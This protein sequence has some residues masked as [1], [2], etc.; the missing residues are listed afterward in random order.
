M[1]D[2][3]LLIGLAILFLGIGVISFIAEDHAA[4]VIAVA[5]AAC[6]FAFS[7]RPPE[8]RA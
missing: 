6:F 7:T 8:G 3:N 2:A 4:A 5:A 1:R